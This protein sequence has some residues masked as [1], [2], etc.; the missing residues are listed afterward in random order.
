MTAKQ[1]EAKMILSA[2]ARVETS[3]AHGDCVEEFLAAPLANVVGLAEGIK[4]KNGKPTGEPALLVLVTHKLEKTDLSA[5][6][7]VPAKLGKMQT[8]VLAVGFPFAGGG[9]EC[10]GAGIQTLGKRV[11]PAQGGYSVG[12]KNITAGTIATCVYDMLPGGTISPPAHGV[13]IPTKFYILSNNH[14]L[15]NSNA[16]SPGDAVLQPGPYDGGTDPAD[17]IASLTRFIPITFSPATPLGSHNNLVD[18]ALA[19]GEFHD[20]NRLIY[21]NGHVRGWRRKTGVTVGTVVKKTGRTTNFTTGRITA[22]N[23]TIDVGYGGGNVARFKDQ[24]VTTNMSAGGDSGSL[25][26]TLDNIAVG[27]LF[28]GSTSSMIANQ[29]EN[30][31]ALLRIDVAEQVL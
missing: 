4:W 28:A 30:V 23:A 11:R 3:K 15:A 14:V 22:V 24:F 6:D 26:T 27:L 20:L 5:K 17:R 2:K 12:H 9:P 10:A 18:A 21:W 31:R 29:I 1:D 19:E 7:L 8:D 25:V 16:G 13:G